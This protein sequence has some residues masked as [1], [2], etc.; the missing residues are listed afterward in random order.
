[1][2]DTPIAA[3]ARH[4]LGQRR[5]ELNLIQANQ[6]AVMCALAPI[7]GQLGIDHPTD[8][9]RAYANDAGR[10]LT[11]LDAKLNQWRE[12]NRQQSLDDGGGEQLHCSG[13][14]R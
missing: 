2:S 13:P 1:M 8:A 14:D 6:I 9:I 7:A 11:H 3:R 5:N 4:S 10:T 12:A